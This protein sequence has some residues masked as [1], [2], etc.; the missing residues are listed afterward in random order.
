MQQN[1]VHTQ[2]SQVSAYARTLACMCDTGKLQ[3]LER[4]CP[5]GLAA[6][7]GK[8]GASRVLAIW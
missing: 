6:E 7:K 8:W 5:A 2:A 4:C 3:S 1:E